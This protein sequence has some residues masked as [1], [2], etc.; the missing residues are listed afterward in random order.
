MGKRALRIGAGET[1]FTNC[2]GLPEF[3]PG[4]PGVNCTGAPGEGR[5]N[6]AIVLPLVP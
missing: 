2:N 4:L 3:G 1:E 6:Q 5:Y